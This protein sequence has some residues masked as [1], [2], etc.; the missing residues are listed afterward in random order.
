M[1][2]YLQVWN[3]EMPKIAPSPICES[4]CV[5]KMQSN[6]YLVPTGSYP[7]VVECST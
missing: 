7:G 1:M 4:N 5:V 6:S 2:D 3:V